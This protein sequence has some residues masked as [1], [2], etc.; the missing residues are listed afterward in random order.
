MKINRKKLFYF[1]LLAVLPAIFSGCST[2]NLEFH[3]PYPGQTSSTG[4]PVAGSI[5]ASISG[6]YLFY[7][8]PLWSGHPKFPNQREYNTFTDYVRPKYM[9]IMLE[10]YRKRHEYDGIEDIEVKTYSSGI[11]TLW[12][13]WTKDIRAH[14]VAVRYPKKKAAPAEVVPEADKSGDEAK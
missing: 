5:D 10:N 12:I 4:K 3:R 2:S 14:A 8:I 9:S 6:V 7:Y 11:W 1:A 13:F